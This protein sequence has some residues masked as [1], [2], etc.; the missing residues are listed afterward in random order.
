MEKNT[1]QLR[2]EIY[3]FIDKNI[4]KISPAVRQTI[5]SY[6]IEYARLYNLIIYEENILLKENLIKNKREFNEEMNKL[7]EKKGMS[8]FNYDF[9]KK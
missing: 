5:K 1:K 2:A 7:R 3:N 4:G 8:Y 9:L 6:L